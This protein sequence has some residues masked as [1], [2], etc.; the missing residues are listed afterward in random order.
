MSCDVESLSLYLLALRRLYLCVCVCVSVCGLFSSCGERGLLL[1]AACGLLIA[2]ASLVEHGLWDAGLNRFG[3][4][5]L[6]HRLLWHTG[7][8][9]PWHVGSSRARD[10]TCTCCI[11]R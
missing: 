9:A 8:A 7:L 4:R 3:S 1:I 6:A 5:V 10:G 11:G 2:L